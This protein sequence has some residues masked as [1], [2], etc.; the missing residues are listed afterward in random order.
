[1][2]TA[3][4][5]GYRDAAKLNKE[6]REAGASGLV[7]VLHY[8]SKARYC[9]LIKEHWLHIALSSTWRFYDLTNA[10]VCQRV[11]ELLTIVAVCRKGGRS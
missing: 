4:A 3:T 11:D 2:T 8:P 10:E 6:I 7:Q 9:L 1:M 5:T